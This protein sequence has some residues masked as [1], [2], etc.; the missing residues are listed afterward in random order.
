MWKTGL[1]VRSAVLKPHAGELVVGWVTTSESS[2]L[3]VFWF[4]FCFSLIRWEMPSCYMV[5]SLFLC[6]KSYYKFHTNLIAY[7]YILYNIV[8]ENI[9]TLAYMYYI[10]KGVA[11][12]PYSYPMY[13]I[14]SATSWRYFSVL[15]LRM[16]APGRFYRSQSAIYV[17]REE[18]ISLI[19]GFDCSWPVKRQRKLQICPIAPN[20]IPTA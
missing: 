9:Y 10:V 19:S 2:L 14:S 4:W 3:Y 17:I 6:F 16:D 13:L 7:V 1:P 12:V 8:L 18:S 5:A 11:H 20:R 15:G